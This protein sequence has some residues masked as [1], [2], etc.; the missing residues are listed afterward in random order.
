MTLG[1]SV[2]KK[3][4]AVVP[5]SKKLVCLPLRVCSSNAPL[6]IQALVLTL[7][8]KTRL[9]TLSREKRN[10]TWCKCCKT[11][12]FAAVPLSK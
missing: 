12:L 6:S 5:L 4:L 11:F 8:C 10:D 1:V 2:I 7:K 3:V 9:K